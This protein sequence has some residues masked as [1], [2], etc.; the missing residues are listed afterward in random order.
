M[1]YLNPLFPKCVW[2]P[3]QC[4]R[5]ISKIILQPHHMLPNIRQWK[6][7]NWRKKEKWNSCTLNSLNLQNTSTSK[8][9]SPSEC[10]W[11]QGVQRLHKLIN[12]CVGS[13]QQWLVC[14]WDLMCYFILQYK[15]TCTRTPRVG[16]MD[17]DW[18]GYNFFV[19]LIVFKKKELWVCACT[20]GQRFSIWRLLRTWTRKRLWF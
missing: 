7:L 14:R 12:F 10:F 3:V 8:C 18:H 5:G 6:A 16:V 15:L 20:V 19:V 4:Q 11:W 9:H 13:P 17:K 2:I 1:K